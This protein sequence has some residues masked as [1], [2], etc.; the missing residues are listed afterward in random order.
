MQSK[1]YVLQPVA[2]YFSHSLLDKDDVKPDKWLI[3]GGIHGV[4]LNILW[5]IA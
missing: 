2:Y 5:L 4:N 1:L 3:I